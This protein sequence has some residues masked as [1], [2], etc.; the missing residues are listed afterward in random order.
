MVFCCMNRGICESLNVKIKWCAIC[1]FKK[2]NIFELCT[3]PFIF[4]I[5]S[6]KCLMRYRKAMKCS[7]IIQYQLLNVCFFSSVT[8]TKHDLIIWAN[9]LV[10]RPLVSHGYNISRSVIVAMV[11]YLTADRTIGWS[12]T[13][14]KTTNPQPSHTVQFI[15]ALLIFTVK[16]NYICYLG[17][18]SKNQMIY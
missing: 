13:L 3:F 10:L 15:T 12:I 17:S 8:L 4:E 1:R 14:E 6:W 7:Y 9:C 5:S 11:C 2:N 16:H 18:Y